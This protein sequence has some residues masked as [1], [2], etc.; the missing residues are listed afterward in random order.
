MTAKAKR[1]LAPLYSYYHNPNPD[2]NNIC[3]FAGQWFTVKNVDVGQ[4]K[5]NLIGK[6]SPY[7]YD[8]FSYYD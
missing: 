2:P 8:G 6:L 4:N 5:V 3:I 7:P 1:D